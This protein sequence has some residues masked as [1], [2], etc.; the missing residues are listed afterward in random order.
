MKRFFSLLK[1]TMV[2]A[3]SPRRVIFALVRCTLS[4]TFTKSGSWKEYCW[5][6][7][8]RPSHSQ[9][10]RWATEGSSQST[11]QQNVPGRYDRYGGSTPRQSGI[12]LI[13]FLYYDTRGFT[14]FLFLTVRSG[15]ASRVFPGHR[16]KAWP[17]KLK[18]NYLLCN[19]SSS[20]HSSFV[21]LSVQS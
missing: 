1:L 13:H 5:S 21:H 14:V 19:F 11:T 15:L 12:R 18:L 16:N 20:L 10:T 9:Y 17:I 2:L 3:R 7:R 8:C 6:R 4:P